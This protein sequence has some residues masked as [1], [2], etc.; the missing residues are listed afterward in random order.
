MQLEE[1]YG[2]KNLLMKDLCENEAIVKIVTGNEDAR[3]PNHDLPYTQI[4]PFEFVPETVGDGKTYICF[5]ID[6]VSVP[7]KTYLTPVI[8]VWVFTHKSLLRL[9]NGEGCLLDKLCIEVNQM[10]NGSR[11][12]GLGVT[13]LDSVRRFAPIKDYLG[14]CLTYYTLDWNRPKDKNWNGPANRPKY[15]RGE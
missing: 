13:K 3:V 8:Y 14:R 2:Y 1:F 4:Y 10:I 9:P 6:I 7:N 15:Q 5:D 12:F 11:F